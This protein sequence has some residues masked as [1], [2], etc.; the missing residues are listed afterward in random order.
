MLPCV[1]RTELDR[2]QAYTQ[3]HLL[4]STTCPCTM[5]AIIIY[6][7][8]YAVRRRPTTTAARTFEHTYFCATGSCCCCRGDQ[9]IASESI[10]LPEKQSRMLPRAIFSVSLTCRLLRSDA[11]LQ[12]DIAAKLFSRPLSQVRLQPFGR[13]IFGQFCLLSDSLKFFLF[14]AVSLTKSARQ[15]PFGD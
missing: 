4:P 8:C 2:G 9:A 6:I 14:L 13:C 12:I 5:R 1:S 11:D 15:H 7:S 10:G 3:S